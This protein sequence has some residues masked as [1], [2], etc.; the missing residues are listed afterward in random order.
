MPRRA[1]ERGA[2]EAGCLPNLL[3]GGRPVTD[4]AA[5][6]DLGT[7]WGTTVPAATG[8]DGD[9]IL[10]GVADGSVTALVVGGVDPVDLPDPVAAAAAIEAAGF[11]VSLEVRASA[12]SAAADV[13]FPV[14][15]VAEKA[16]TFVDWE[17]RVRPF[18]RVLGDAGG[19][20]DLRVLAGIAD[21][22]GVDLGF[23]TVDQARAEMSEVGAWDGERVQP[24][25][26][27]AA[28]SQP[29]DG[30]LRLAT[31]KPLI[32]DGRML[33][34]EEYLRATA[35]TPVAL[36]SA[37]TLAG[38]AAPEGGSVTLAGPTGEVG[39]PVGV[40]DLPDGVVWAPTSALRGLGAR[41]GSDVRLSANGAG[42]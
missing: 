14:A 42:A 24:A 40:A 30:S 38:L 27:T 2:V 19:L 20:P 6:V 11:V 15:P 22:I 23:R 41:A 16:G 13:V 32:D 10:A 34:G 9:A 12:V 18:E 35:R 7:V 25:P 26:V 3:P 5:R 4:A 8:R 31:W 39:L 21:E 33:D 28:P 29:A 37:A 17:G 1:G 36:V